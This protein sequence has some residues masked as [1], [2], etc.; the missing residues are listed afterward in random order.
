MC[1]GGLALIFTAPL[2]LFVEDDPNDGK[3]LGEQQQ[4]ER[5]Q[6]ASYQHRTVVCVSAHDPYF[7][8]RATMAILPSRE[9]PSISRCL[10]LLLPGRPRPSAPCFQRGCSVRVLSSFVPPHS[11]SYV[12]FDHHP[13]TSRSAGHSLTRSRRFTTIAYKLNAHTSAINGTN[14][15]HYKANHTSTYAYLPFFSSPCGTYNFALLSLRP[16]LFDGFR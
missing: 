13:L 9:T 16:L 7:R 11:T 15:V 1:T 4:Q 12:L 5:E 8:T 2:V 10:L 6:W 14:A 3:N